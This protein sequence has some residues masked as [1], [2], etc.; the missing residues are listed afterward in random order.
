MSLFLTP[1]HADAIR[2]HAEE[3]YPDEV[4]GLLLGSFR[5]G[6]QSHEYERVVAEVY[7]LENE[8]TDERETR[9]S[10]SGRSMFRA[11]KYAQQRGLDLIGYYHSHPD[12]PAKP[13]RYDLD[14]ATWPGISYPIVSVMLGR[15]AA[16]KS[17]VL[18]EDR[19][20]YIPEEIY[21]EEPEE[22]EE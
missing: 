8:R 16:L 22:D 12:A 6:N 2:E 10:V 21:E 20:N 9:Y 15:V 13:S 14:H 5:R 17:Y 19:E 4:C 11:E 1:D 7:R 3:G 18:D